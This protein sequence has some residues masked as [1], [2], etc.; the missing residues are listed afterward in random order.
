MVYPDYEA[1]KESFLEV[2]KIFH[3]VLLEKERLFTK[4]QPNAIRYDKDSVQV[5]PQNALDV[6]VIAMDE[7]KIDKR[8]ETS[9]QLLK[10][11]EKLLSLKED[12]LRQSR[13]KYD[14]VYVCRFLENM[15]INDIATKLHYSPSYTYKLFK[16]IK[17]SKRG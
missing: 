14:R 7:K 12:E 8:L 11:R 9:R 10:D 2:Q 3:E 4:T 5:V 1:Y 13:D 15:K 6:Y 16:K 17:F